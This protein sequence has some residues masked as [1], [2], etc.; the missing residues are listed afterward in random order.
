M[1][2][3]A[4]WYYLIGVLCVADGLL[5]LFMPK[6][7]KRLLKGV[8]RRVSTMRL[9]GYAA[10]LVGVAMWYSA[11]FQEGIAALILLVL[12]YLVLVKVLFLLY[13]PRW[14]RKHIV[15]NVIKWKEVYYQLT[16]VCVVTLG[17]VSLIYAVLYI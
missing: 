6:E 9:M 12:S 10:I 16:G 14:I 4:F 3:V 5:L 15:K 13:A 17:L 2:D 8:T 7:A 11:S 1:L